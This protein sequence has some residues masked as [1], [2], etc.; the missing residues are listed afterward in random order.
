MYKRQVSSKADWLKSFSTSIPSNCPGLRHSS[1]CVHCSLT[2]TQPFESRSYVELTLAALRDFGV[3]VNWADE[4]RMKLLIPGGQCG[5]GRDYRVEGDYSQAAFF[6][7]LGA[8]LG[9]VT[10]EDLRP[11]SLQ[12]DGAILP[13]LEGCGARF[14]RNGSSVSF[15]KAPL[16]GTVIDLA[17]CPDLGP[18]LMT[19]ALFCEEIGRAHV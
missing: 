3:Q 1:L 11:D 8:V 14:V 18:I 12:G 9:G 2:I 6:A 13:I 19:L 17:D 4:T 7:V 5:R 16:S 10:I 15:E